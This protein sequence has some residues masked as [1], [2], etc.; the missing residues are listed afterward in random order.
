MVRRNLVGVLTI[1]LAVL[2]IS[3]AGYEKERLL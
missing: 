1:F 2:Q 3:E